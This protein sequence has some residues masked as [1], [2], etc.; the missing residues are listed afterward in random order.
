M[1]QIAYDLTNS[2]QDMLC[3]F[4]PTSTKPAGD[5][6]DVI[7]LLTNVHKQLSK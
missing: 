4:H 3:M 2:V 7:A 1:K 6:Q 5:D